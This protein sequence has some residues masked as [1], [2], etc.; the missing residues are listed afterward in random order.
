MRLDSHLFR[1]GKRAVGFLLSDRFSPVRPHRKRELPA[2]VE[3]LRASLSSSERRR[4]RQIAKKLTTEFSSKVVIIT[5]GDPAELDRI[6]RDVD[7]VAKKTWQHKLGQGGFDASEALKARL[8][9]E[10]EIG[11][12]RVYLLYIGGKP[13]A[14]WVG[15]IYQQ[16]FYSDFTGYDPAYARYS[17][18]TYLLS[19]ILEDLCRIGMKA[20]DFG[21]TDDDYK[22]RFGNVEWLETNLHL[23]P[24]TLLGM[25]L[26]GMR[27]ATALISN[28]SRA[29]LQQTGLMQR[30]KKNVAES[31]QPRRF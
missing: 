21:F 17:L 22:R 15:A 6:L 9:T 11:A 26:S 19:Q 5:L 31:R 25:Q 2:T 20:I 4:F 18:G 27:A 14:F 13:A 24:P 8:Q 12:L 16:T 28:A 29:M 10:A 1:C 30:V 3:E 23:F 7:D